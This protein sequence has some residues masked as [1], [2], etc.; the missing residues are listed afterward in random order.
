M[1][2]R[3]WECQNEAAKLARKEMALQ[4]LIDEALVH[5]PTFVAFC[6]GVCQDR[7]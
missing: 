2:H 6:R 5:G 4:K 1:F 3:L 7:P